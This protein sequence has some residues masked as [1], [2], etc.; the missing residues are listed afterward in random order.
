[1][2]I[3][4]SQSA[5]L[6]PTVESGGTISSSLPSMRFI[7]FSI[8]RWVRSGSGGGAM[9]ALLIMMSS[10]PCRSTALSTSASKAAE[11]PTSNTAVSPFNSMA[12]ADAAS[13]LMSLTTMVAPSAAR[14][15]ANAAPRP[16]PPPV[17]K[18]TWP[19]RSP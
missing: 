8:E 10:R 2:R 13:A 17:M 5:S 9:P 12:T 3:I 1:M 11:S 15:R 19:V 4:R 16:E 6:S 14:R 18:A 7:W